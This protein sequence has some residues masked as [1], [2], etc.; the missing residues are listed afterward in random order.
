MGLVVYGKYGI[1]TGKTI[2]RYYGKNGAAKFPYLMF[3]V[4][5]P[6]LLHPSPYLPFLFVFLLLSSL[7]FTSFSLL[8]SD[9]A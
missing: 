4:P 9:E 8:L 1:N 3:S 2:L 6:F 7:S 5:R